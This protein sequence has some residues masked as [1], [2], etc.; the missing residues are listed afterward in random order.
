M[1]YVVRSDPITEDGRRALILSINYIG[2]PE[3][4]VEVEAN[5][6]LGM[7]VRFDIIAAAHQR[8]SGVRLRSHEGGALQDAG[9]QVHNRIAPGRDSTF[10]LRLNL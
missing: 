1:G 10:F 7:K 2:G 6:L 5:R 9:A 4:E 3:Y 8:V